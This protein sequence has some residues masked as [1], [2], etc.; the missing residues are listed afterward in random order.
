MLMALM[1]G[2]AHTARE[3]AAA[4]DVAAPTASFH[5]E[6]LVNAGLLGVVRQGRFRYF[7][8]QSEDAARMLE[9]LLALHHAPRPR[10]IPLTCPPSLR[11]A[12]VCYKHIAG[13]LGV[14]IYRMLISGN[15]LAPR[16]ADFILLPA[17]ATL[18]ASLNI[19]HQDREILARPCLDWSE[20]EFHLAGPLGD[21]LFAAMIRE[22]WLLRGSGR[23]L[24]V[25]VD[26]ER[27]LRR[28]SNIM[29]LSLP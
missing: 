20:R 28:W 12:R 16:G 1:D 17:A 10:P 27:Q 26:G 24:T 23:Q 3:L 2:R 29:G 14:R 13:R 7:R 5:L 9:S 8:L 19:P 21:L 22:R 6:K 11:E 4:A 25:T 15:M 18:L